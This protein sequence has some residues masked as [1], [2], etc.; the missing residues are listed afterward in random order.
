MKQQKF[1]IG[2]ILELSI[3]NGE[4]YVYAQMLQY[5]QVAFFDF[6]SEIK[7]DNFEILNNCRILFIITVWEKVITDGVWSKVGKL[8]IRE[9]LLTP[10]NQYGYI[11]EFNRFFLRDIAQNKT[12]YCK[13]EDAVGLELWCGIYWDAEK[14]EDRIK[15]HYNNV[16]CKWLK[17]HYRI[18]ET[19]KKYEILGFKDAPE[20]SSLNKRN[21]ISNTTTRK[22]QRCIEGAILEIPINNGEY[23][24]Y[25]QILKLE[26]I[27][28]FDFRSK[29]PLTELNI[30]N[31]CNIICVLT[32]YRD[33]ITSGIWLIKG[34]LPIQDS[35][36]SPP[37][38]YIYNWENNQFQ[39]Y[40][41]LS[42]EIT[43]CTRKDV[44]G[45]ELC[46]VW[47]SNNVEDRIIAYYN[48][49]K[50]IWSDM[51]LLI[52]TLTAD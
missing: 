43:M 13:K 25:A 22:R 33:I 40:H 49:T 15:D 6:R 1:T 29:S 4:Y 24:V 36:A 38:Q 35:L 30:L 31:T 16:K 23:Y 9:S 41:V 10:P 19:T 37:N 18:W 51:N 17:R 32:I 7:L 39:L 3:N 20:F 44:I 28:V 52:M 8:S 46:A 45:L 26:Q 2:G 21:K 12:I 27:A 14:V 50:N 5:K 48:N 42:G 11:W 34:N 47:D